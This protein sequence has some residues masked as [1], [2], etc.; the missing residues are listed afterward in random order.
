MVLVCVLNSFFAGYV[1]LAFAVYLV[2]SISAMHKGCLKKMQDEAK[3][4]IIPKY[5]MDVSQISKI[6][7]IRFY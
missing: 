3:H 2:D 7:F 1:T 4:V 6:I 5:N